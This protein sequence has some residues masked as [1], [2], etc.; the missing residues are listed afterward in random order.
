MKHHFKHS[1]TIIVKGLS[2][3]NAD[4]LPDEASLEAFPNEREGSI[5]VGKADYLPDEASLVA[6]LKTLFAFFHGGQPKSASCDVTQR[7]CVVNPDLYLYGARA[8][9]LG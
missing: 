7:R 6:F 8:V 2:L 5:V 9:Y 3:G 1:S 4:Y